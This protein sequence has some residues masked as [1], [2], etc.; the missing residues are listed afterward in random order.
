MRRSQLQTAG[1][2]AE[3]GGA[4]RWRKPSGVKAVWQE[5]GRTDAQSTVGG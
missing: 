5:G 2:A 1:W 3:W 4:I